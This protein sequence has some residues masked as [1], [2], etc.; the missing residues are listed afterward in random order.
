M[1]RP[2]RL[3]LAGAHYLVTARGQPPTNLFPNPQ[4]S[5]LFVE[6]LG[7]SCVRYHWRCHAWCLTS[8]YYQLVIAT[9][10]A[11]LATGMRH[12]NSVYSQACRRRY[13]SRG[14]LFEGRYES[15]LIDPERYLGD[16]V[17]GVLRA[18]VS[19]GLVGRACDW[20]WSSYRATTGTSESPPWLAS[21]DVLAHFA[22]ERHTA[23]RAL[24]AAVEREPA[25]DDDGQPQTIARCLADAAFMARILE[26]AAQ[27]ADEA[28]APRL[29]RLSRPPLRELCTAHPLRRD[30]MR[31]AF[32]LG[33]TQKEIARYFNVHTA[34]VSRAVSAAAERVALAPL[35]HA[36]ARHAAD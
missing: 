21:D 15:R 19:L 2:L 4:D 32:R 8:D 25:A 13:R 36:T 31:A 1:P 26:H 17:S 7:R 11:N 6:L 33:Y 35:L 5:L 10:T 24:M 29:M 28:L 27:A 9:E 18:P 14:G 23:L 20:P 12:L 30:A 16:A 22:G 3:Q 34:T